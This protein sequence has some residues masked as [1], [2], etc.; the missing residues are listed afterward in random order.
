MKRSSRLSQNFLR[1][2]R[3]VAELVGIAHITAND[4]V[5]DIGAGSG[6]ISSVLARRAG[7]VVAIEHDARLVE[8]LRRNLKNFSNVEIHHA[9]ALEFDFGSQPYKIFANIP[10]HLS[11]QLVQKIAGTP[12]A[13]DAVYLIVQKQFAY[14][15]LIEKD[16]FTSALGAVIAPWFSARVRA[17]LKRTDFWPHPAVDTVLLELLP[18]EVPLLGIANRAAYRRFVERCFADIKYFRSVTKNSVAVA[19]LALP[20][21]LK[22]AHWTGLFRQVAP[23]D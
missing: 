15:L 1:S 10:F 23:A 12:H 18:L 21:R 20:S 4:T 17:H 8:T 2:P 5:Y 3:K 19:P 13:P 7:K 16:G 11:S 9:D 14:K 6:V 22:V